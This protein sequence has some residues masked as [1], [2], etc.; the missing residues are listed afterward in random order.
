MKSASRTPR[1]RN[2]ETSLTEALEELAQRASPT[3]KHQAAAGRPG[4]DAL[5]PEDADARQLAAAREGP[6]DNATGGIGG[7]E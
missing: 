6:E 5:G 7:E 4:P 3:R 2:S 1:R